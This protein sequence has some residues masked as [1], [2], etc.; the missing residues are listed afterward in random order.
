[1]Y[2]AL[3]RQLIEEGRGAEAFQ[4]ADRARAFEPLNLALK[5]TPPA[6]TLEQVQSLLP[7][8]TFLIEY[9][10]LEDRTYAWVLSN[11]GWQV[12]TLPVQRETIEHWTSALHRAV[13]ARDLDTVDATLRAAYDALLTAPLAA[14]HNPHPRL[15]FVPDGAMD[16]LP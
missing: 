10:I 3:I 1:T 14:I 15:I 12:L 16:G 2:H 7:P 13:P 4:Y 5:L 9:S 11:S 6:I 8:G